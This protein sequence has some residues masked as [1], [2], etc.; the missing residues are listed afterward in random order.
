MPGTGLEKNDNLKSSSPDPDKHHKAYYRT[1][2][3][4]KADV[5]FPRTKD[6]SG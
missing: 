5:A 4:R 2:T 1:M 3:P 6:N